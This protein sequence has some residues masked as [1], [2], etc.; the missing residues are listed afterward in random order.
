MP[1]G[2][3]RASGF[4]LGIDSTGDHFKVQAVRDESE[5]QNLRTSETSKNLLL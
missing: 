2:P 1:I 5:I 3:Y 4:N